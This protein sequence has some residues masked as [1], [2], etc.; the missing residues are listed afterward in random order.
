MAK[1]KLLQNGVLDKENNMFIPNDPANRHWQEYQQWLLEGN[2]PEPE[3]TL[4]ELKQLKLQE[5]KKGFKNE[6]KVGMI[7]SSL[8][9]PVD[10]RRWE[11][12]NDLENLQSLIKLNQYPIYFKDA[13]GNIQEL[14]EENAKTLEQELIQ[15]CLNRYQKK[16]QL[17]E[18]INNATTTEE[19]DA[20]K[21]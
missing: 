20:I 13:D 12:K 3:H 9:F 18:Q 15:A 5:I 21:W 16:W 2:N 11:E 7:Q 17:E 8:G 6:F 4:E 1:Y 19:L 14:T 10:A